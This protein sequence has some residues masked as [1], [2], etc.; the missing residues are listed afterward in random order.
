MVTGFVTLI[1]G[2]LSLVMFLLTRKAKRD[3][4]PKIQMEKARNEDAKL[5]VK[6]DVTRINTR[7]DDLLN[8]V[9]DLQGFAKR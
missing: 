8:R 9:S 4:D 2:I 3:D 5:I 1:G 6:S 7:L